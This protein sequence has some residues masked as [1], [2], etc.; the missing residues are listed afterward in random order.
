MSTR[1]ILLSIAAVMLLSY[2]VFV[3]TVMSSYDVLWW[4]VKDAP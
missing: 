1:N 3:V 2:V 4:I